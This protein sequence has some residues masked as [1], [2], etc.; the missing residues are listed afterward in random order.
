VARLLRALEATLD[1]RYAHSPPDG[2]VT[3]AFS[4]REEFQEVMDRAFTLM[5]EDSEMG[6][7]MRSADLPQRFDFPDLEMVVNVRSGTGPEPNLAWEWSD[8]VDWEPKVR[9]SMSSETAN[10]YFQGKENVAMA[11]AR[12]EIRI[13]GDSTAALITIPLREPVFADYPH[14]EE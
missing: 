5:S 11:I 3:A 10:R 14:L 8:D 2:R 9:V 13:R 7:T 6:P 12:R 4:S 1:F